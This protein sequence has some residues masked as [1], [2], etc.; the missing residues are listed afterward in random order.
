[1]TFAV[2]LFGLMLAGGP[3]IEASLTEQV[4]DELRWRIEH[5]ELQALVIDDAPLT[6]I[7]SLSAFY[8][9]RAFEPGWV[10]DEGVRPE[11]EAVLETLRGA[12]RH[13]LH[14][15]VYNVG[16]IA[17]TL[18]Q[19]RARAEADEAPDVA[20]LADLDLLLTDAFLLY[21]S[22]LLIGR[23]DPEALDARWRAN[24]RDLDMTA[25]L[26][27]ALAT[28]A[29][30]AA[31]A[32]F[33]PS[34]PEYRTLMDALAR[35]RDV[36]AAGGWRPIP[37]GPTMRR[38]DS[39]PR[40]AALRNRLRTTGDLPTA[41]DTAAADVFD[42][43]LHAAAQAFQT[44]HGLEVDGLVGQQSLRA[45]NVP[46]GQRVQQIVLNLER[47][48]WLPDDLG[49]RHIR[50]NIAAFDLQVMEGLDAVMDMRV[51]VGRPYRSTPVFSDRITYLAL[52]PYWNVPPR[53]AVV[54]ILP[55][56][57]RDVDYLQQ[58]N[59]R[60]FRG[61]G[62]GAEAIDPTTIDWQT[63]SPRN[64]PYRFRQE[65]GPNNALGDVKFMFPNA[66]NVYLHDSPAREL[67]RRPDRSFSSGC[68]R[69][70]RPLELAEYLLA[71]QP[72]W[73]RQRL[74]QVIGQ[75]VERAVTLRQPMPIHLL[76]WTAFVRENGTVNF[77]NDVYDRDGPLRDALRA[78]SPS[79]TTLAD[80]IPAATPPTMGS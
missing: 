67:F 39:G 34:H 44:R 13:G 15:G 18:E 26:N 78:L 10:T 21:G 49:E 54:D 72:G 74:Q 12:D 45:L 65:P 73:T 53:M 27:D 52:A 41:A 20:R 38:G 8:L 37:E 22:H 60:V 4:S 31:L 24:R 29:P 42:D 46:A 43:A 28:G 35:Y 58:Q 40:V 66:F 48:R 5:R 68:I 57:Q 79:E 14:A 77:R 47:W 3:S 59:M 33:A 30:A 80:I 6:T 55:Q 76:Y 62:A 71:D 56:V 32:G 19:I 7:E 2:L 70:E 64:F 23:V 11:A 17:R 1:M 61:W 51:V 63:L 50:V 9:E 25:Q 69:V 36:E 75:R 16:L